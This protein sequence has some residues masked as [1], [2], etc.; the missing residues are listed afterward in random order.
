MT[1]LNI[2]EKRL[3]QDGKIQVSMG[4]SQYD[5]RV[6][7]LPTPHGETLNVRILPHASMFKC[8]GD[9]G[10]MSEDLE[11]IHQYI[12]RLY[13][14]VLFTGPTG[15]GKSTTLYS[16]LNRLNQI[17][18]K[19]I[20]IENPIE[21]QLKGISQMQAHPQNVFDFTEGLRLMLLH[22]PDVIMLR[23]IRDYET[24]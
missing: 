2:A 4:D 12:E 16:S 5:L 6:S 21:F 18:R 9:L 22:D 1:N 13:G 15:S 7:L 17:D 24:A 11:S 3:P 14:N 19:I 8:L 20:I 10:Y 23:E